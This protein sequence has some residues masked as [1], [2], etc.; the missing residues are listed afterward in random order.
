MES[1]K[2]VME[3]E[4]M[5][6]VVV[7]ICVRKRV[8]GPDEFLL[9]KSKKDFGAYSGHWYPPGGH[10]EDGEDEKDALIREVREELGA[11][12]EPVEKLAETPGDVENQITSWWTCHL[13]SDKIMINHEEIAE[14]GWFT[15]DEMEQLFLWPATKRFFEDY[16]KHRGV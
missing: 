16:W 5:N 13:P 12:V 8:A 9:V 4:R 3:P 2:N 10:V 1:T 6:H 14:A 7:G 11:E 15:R